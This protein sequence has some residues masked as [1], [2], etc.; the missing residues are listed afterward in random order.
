MDFS[1]VTK[2]NSVKR[3]PPITPI[4]DLDVAK[5]DL[6][7]YREQISNMVKEAMTL[8]VNNEKSNAVAVELGTQAKK[9]NKTIEG[10]KKRIIEQPNDFI[11]AVRNFCKSFQDELAKVEFTLKQKITT[12]QTRRELER[13][14]AEEEARKAT[15]EL[16]KK[17]DKEAKKAGVEAPKIETPVIPQPVKVTRTDYGSSHIRKEWTFE[18]IEPGKIPQEYMKVDEQAIRKAIKAG[19]RKI[20]GIRIY[21]ETKTVFRS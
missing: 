8:T 14:K 11:K 4:L 18:I 16:Q 5:R 3:K 12:Y 19:V 6:S 2:I 21:Q 17:I 13:R 1:K 7:P 9:L 10:E 15:E 20:A